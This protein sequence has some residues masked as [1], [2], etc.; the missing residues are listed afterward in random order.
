[1][2]GG[3]GGIMGFR[4]QGLGF[5]VT[6]KDSI[7]YFLSIHIKSFHRQPFSIGCTSL[8]LQ[9]LGTSNDRSQNKLVVRLPSF[10]PGLPGNTAFL[11]YDL[12]S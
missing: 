7:I 1:V 10:V 2:G 8:G 5:M 11:K 6:K 3:V 9:P 12:N 4:D